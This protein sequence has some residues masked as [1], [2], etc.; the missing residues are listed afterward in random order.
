MPTPSRR[1]T[2]CAWLAALAAALLGASAVAALIEEPLPP[3]PPSP[4]AESRP[5]PSAPEETAP[6]QPL[7]P[8]APPP[9]SGL[10]RDNALLIGGAPKA[11]FWADGLSRPEDLPAYAALGFNAVR[12]PVTSPAGDGLAKAE[13]LAD[14]AERAGLLILAD[15]APETLGTAPQSP[16]NASYRAA[17]RGFVRAVVSHLQGRKGLAAWVVSGVDA[18]SVSYAQQDFWAYLQ[19]WHGGLGDINAAWGS[20]FPTALRITD[21]SIRALD[22]QR[23][24]GVGL[25]TL[26]LAR[27][28]QQAY[29]DLLGLWADEIHALDRSRPVLAGRVYN[30]RSAISVPAGKFEGMVCGFFPGVCEDD[31]L[32]HNAQGIDIA[33]RGNALAPLVVLTTDLAAP[34]SQVSAWVAE[35]VVHG[36]AG[37][38]FS[39]WETIRGAA[40]PSGIPQGTG[41]QREI[42]EAIRINS[43]MGL[44]PATPKARIAVLY[45][46]FAAGAL[47]AGV[48]LYGYAR[49]LSDKE[50]GRLFAAL[51][52][53]TRFGPVDYITEQQLLRITPERYSVLLAPLAV[54]LPE[55]AQRAIARYVEAGGNLVADLGAGMCQSGGDMTAPPPILVR[56]F[57]L[58]T[59]SRVE[60]QG[61]VW[62]VLS[63]QK[64]FP[65]LRVGDSPSVNFWSTPFSGLTTFLTV[66]PD[67]VPLLSSYEL[68]EKYRGYCGLLM[69]PVGKGYAFYATSRLWEEWLPGNPVFDKLFGDLIGPNSEVAVVA[70]AS[71]AS[72]CEVVPRADGGLL[73]NNATPE[74]AQVLV[75][76]PQRRVYRMPGG[77]QSIRPEGNSANSL[78]VVPAG[79][80]IAAEPL[81]ITVTPLELPAY[82]QVATYKR[83]QIVLVIHPGTSA[84]QPDV[85]GRLA[86]M[87]AGAVAVDVV[88]KDGVY[89]VAPGSA[90]LVIGKPLT[91]DKP[92]EQAYKADAA[93]VLS[94]RC[95]SG[96]SVITIKRARAGASP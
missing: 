45:E 27:Y 59:I 9:S 51:R 41:L 17:V 74:M 76:N 15:L 88:I 40:P 1:L 29:A 60:K 49:G 52:Q 46:P 18:E 85:A 81:P 26:D 92:W 65:S 32:T 86:V 22:A 25:A 94:F 30:Y 31:V 89:P 6:Q 82:V 48:P 57:G 24:G 70:P 96:G 11:L 3:L 43:G 87:P 23:P 71:L 61:P 42:G 64:R 79:Q 73:I 8:P 69:R 19:V 50:P 54:D 7:A 16:L 78:F 33:R 83:E 44:C 37:V 55:S 12:V 91:A 68:A 93:G 5:L 56:L 67:V 95:A 2:K 58:A 36:A 10:R 62:N 80:L 14:A 34:A 75:A 13:R 77:V 39:N 47:Q 84:V 20:Q 66:A 4:P 53:G 90:H 38:G 28:R 21:A 72:R 35:A 63:T